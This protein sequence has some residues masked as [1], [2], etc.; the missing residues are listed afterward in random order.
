MIL[1]KKASLSFF[2]RYY[3]LFL[4]SARLQSALYVV[5]NWKI[6]GKPDK[7][8]IGET[9]SSEE[10]CATSVGYRGKLQSLIPI[11]N[12]R[13]FLEYALDTMKLARE[14][15]LKNVWVTNGFMTREDS[16]SYHPLCDAANVDLKG[17]W[18]ASM[19]YCG[20]RAEYPSWKI[21]NIYLKRVPGN[22][23]PHRTRRK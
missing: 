9:V 5:L 18:E 15:G 4:R 14:K 22:H 12:Q 23:H 13:F 16:G 1:S 3:D 6:S 20:G 2:T 17:L 7:E 21:Y 19:K 8:I 10:A 11:P